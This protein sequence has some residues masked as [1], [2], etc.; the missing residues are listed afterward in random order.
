[1]IVRDGMQRPIMAD[2][3]KVV[4]WLTWVGV[5]ALLAA[6]PLS[7]V[8]RTDLSGCGRVGVVCDPPTYNPF[9]WLALGLT[10]VGVL[11]LTSVAILLVIALVV[12]AVRLDRR[13]RAAA[14]RAPVP[15]GPH[16]S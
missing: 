7:H 14:A 10:A 3:R 13:E 6:W 15:T 2:V 12:R 11:A 5:A 8:A 4:V 1:M 9:A 16:R